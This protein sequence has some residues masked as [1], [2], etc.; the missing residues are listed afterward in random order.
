MHG[1]SDPAGCTC[2]VDLKS[3]GSGEYSGSRPGR[4]RLKSCRHG[5]DASLK[6][7][8]CRIVRRK[9]LKPPLGC[10][11]SR[12]LAANLGGR[13]DSSV[14]SGG[15]W[16]S[17]TNIPTCQAWGCVATGLQPCGSCHLLC[18]AS[19]CLPRSSLAPSSERTGTAVGRSLVREKAARAD[20]SSRL[21]T[22]SCVHPSWVSDRGPTT[23]P[24]S[25]PARRGRFAATRRYRHG[26][27][28]GKTRVLLVSF[29]SW[30]FETVAR[31]PLDPASLPPSSPPRAKNRR[32]DPLWAANPVPRPTRPC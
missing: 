3:G 18:S 12:D 10:L 28:M 24:A 14:R 5:G 7:S 29:R 16:A 15:R 31:G 32:G 30:R 8:P 11:V 17:D 22:L 6:V 13:V 21:T 1:E 26:P 27:C 19:R 25:I 23:T 2:G 4:R 20:L 9:A